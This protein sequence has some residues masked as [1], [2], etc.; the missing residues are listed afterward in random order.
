VLSALEDTSPSVRSAVR[1]LLKVASVSNITCLHAT[2]QALLSNISR[3]PQ[4]VDSTFACLKCVGA[5]HGTFTGNVNTILSNSLEF[6]IEELLHIDPRFMTVEPHPDDIP[7]NGVFITICN[8]AIT[9]PTI[10]SLLPKYVYL[11]ALIFNLHLRYRHFDYLK[12]K[13]PDH[14]PSSLGGTL[15]RE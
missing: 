15:S 8:A 7:Y 11:I 14:L 10:L 4:D 5:R 12:D 13:Y 3:Y 1:N 9:N 2:I 6:L